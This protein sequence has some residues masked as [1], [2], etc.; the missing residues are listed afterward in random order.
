MRGA[1]YLTLAVLLLLAAACGKP[2]EPAPAKPQAVQPASPQP[3]PGGLKQL[4]RQFQDLQQK[5]GRLQG[6]IDRMSPAARARMAKPLAALL[7][8]QDAVA[9][10]LTDL[11]EARDEQARANLR[12]RAQAALQ[13]LQQSCE[14]TLKSVTPLLAREKQAYVNQAAAKLA[15]IRR[16]L[17]S[18][19][20]RIKTSPPAHRRRLSQDS[21]ALHQK[22][23]LAGQ[24]LAALKSAGPVA[25]QDQ[26]PGV[27][28]AVKDLEAACTRL[29]A[30]V[31]KAR[32]YNRQ[33]PSPRRV[34][35]A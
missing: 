25:W 27:K 28:A 17:K 10:K 16:R 6:T 35:A 34:A 23:A 11:G 22:L 4:S 9:Q 14:R 5:I 3:R 24:K 15:D 31:N 26:R 8:Q 18:L 29:A 32:T 12:P 20:A 33:G 21:Q 2:E 13:A 7:Q 30:Q 1:A 19:E